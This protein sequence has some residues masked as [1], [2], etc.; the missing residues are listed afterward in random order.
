MKA[1]LQPHPCC[2]GH[3]ANMLKR[4]GYA[5]KRILQGLTAA[6][7]RRV[8]EKAYRRHGFDTCTCRAGLLRASKV[9]AAQ[10]RLQPQYAYH[11]LPFPNPCLLQPLPSYHT[12]PIPSIC[13]LKLQVQ[14]NEEGWQFYRW[15]FPVL[16]TSQPLWSVPS[17]FEV[18]SNVK[19]INCDTSVTTAALKPAVTTAVRGDA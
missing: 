1:R 9:A 14:A 13:S 6:H 19:G 4:G 12:H 3:H 15:F 16:V 17:Y 7:L 18:R 5:S 8:V 2:I 11:L 10:V